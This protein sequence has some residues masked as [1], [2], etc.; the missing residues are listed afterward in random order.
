VI[1]AG[2]T[3]LYCFDLTFT[4][5]TAIGSPFLFN[6]AVVA[7][8]TPPNAALPGQCPSTHRDAAAQ[9]YGS[10]TGTD[11]AINFQVVFE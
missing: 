8:A 6:S 11:A 10:S 7:T 1:P 9:T 2:E 3:G 5:K 4:P